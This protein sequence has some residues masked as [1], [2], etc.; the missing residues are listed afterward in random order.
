[1]HVIEMNSQTIWIKI[2]E[3]YEK[4]RNLHKTQSF[5]Q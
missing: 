1:M 2:S 3:C 4:I 5:I